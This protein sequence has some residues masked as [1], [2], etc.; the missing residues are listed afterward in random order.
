MKILDNISLSFLFQLTV[1]A[2]AVLIANCRAAPGVAPL[3]STLFVDEKSEKDSLDV[4]EVGPDENWELF[5]RLTKAKTYDYPSDSEK[6]RVLLKEIEEFS[7]LVPTPTTAVADDEPNSTTTDQPDGITENDSASSDWFGTAWKNLAQNDDATAS[8]G[9]G[10]LPDRQDDNSNL[11]ELIKKIST[12]LKK[13]YTKVKE[14]IVVVK[15]WYG[16]WTLVNGVY[17]AAG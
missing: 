2:L 7:R 12:D 4:N 10:S 14:V 1:I 5:N 3:A 16:I 13:L 17:V 9:F 15:N 6:T 8:G 11:E